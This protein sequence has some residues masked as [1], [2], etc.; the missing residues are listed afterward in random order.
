MGP[1]VGGSDLVSWANLGKPVLET[2]GALDD[3]EVDELVDFAELWA[4]VFEAE[5]NSAGT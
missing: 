4:A 2:I 1:T 3:I 5:K